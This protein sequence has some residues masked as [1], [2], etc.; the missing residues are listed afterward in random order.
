MANTYGASDVIEAASAGVEGLADAVTAALDRD[1][2]LGALAHPVL[3]AL[4]GV[5]ETFMGSPV[6]TSGTNWHAYTHEQLHR[7]LWHDADVADVS[8]IAAEWGRHGSELASHADTLRDQ[9]SALQSNWSGQ[10]A[11]VA[12][13]QLCELKDRTA[14]VGGR[15]GA[16]QQAAQDAGDALAAARNAMP[17]PPSDPTGLMLAGTVA[18]AGAGA[19]I[20]G[21]AGA[22][23]GGIGAAPGA[24]MGAAI[25]AVVGGAGSM[26]AANMAAGGQKAEAVRVMQRFESSLTHSSHAVAPSPPGAT[27]ARTYGVDGSGG[28]VTSAA[29]F[30]A[31]DPLGGA[32]G[33]ASGRGVP[34]NQLI[35]G[36][37]LA[38]GARAGAD[39]RASG[40]LRSA[41]AA[42]TALMSE[43][44]AAR[45]S[46]LG[47]MVPGTGANGRREDD[48]RHTNQLPTV[49][50][51]LFATSERV[52]TPVIGQ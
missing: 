47:G 16:V 42:R 25:G 12:A 21:V 32:G 4:Q 48:E 35:G 20:G 19:V 3:D 24:V 11:E 27:E 52:S 1:G 45:G 33:G 13:D 23:A 40:L 44:A 41:L 15:A 5:W 2:P 30:V 38:P 29:G 17:P 7:M 8:A 31:A 28:S 51:R 36:D 50:Q 26:F 43:L 49:D 14:G 18:G 10:A 46:G 22:G 39:L 9:R 34:W 6:P 37:P